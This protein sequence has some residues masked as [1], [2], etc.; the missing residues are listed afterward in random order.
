MPTGFVQPERVLRAAGFTA[1]E[2][3]Y[4]T[5]HW[6]VWE[7]MYA[8]PVRESRERLLF[9]NASCGWAHLRDARAWLDRNAG[10]RS[11]AV[12]TSNYFKLL[13]RED[14]F[15]QVTEVLGQPAPNIL[16]QS[17]FLY[18]ILTHHLGAPEAIGNDSEDPGQ[19]FFI[20]PMVRVP[21]E[22]VPQP[23]LKF[24][25]PWLTGTS[26]VAKDHNFAVLL[27]DGGAGKST[28]ARRLFDHLSRREHQVVPLLIGSRQWAGLGGQKWIELDDI[29]SSAISSCYRGAMVGPEQLET[30]VACGTIVPIFDGFDELCSLFAGSFNP[31]ETIE[32]LLE[33]C[34]E[35]NLL[36][37]SRSRFWRENIELPLASHIDQIDLEPFTLEQR[38][39]Y[40]AL[41]FAESPSKAKN[42]KLILERVR[43]A[44]HSWST[45]AP[46]L[47]EESHSIPSYHSTLDTIPFVV[48]FAAE[49]ADTDSGVVAKYGHLLSSNDPLEGLVLA[50]CERERRRQRLTLESEHQLR[51][52][53]VLATECG[54]LFSLEDI[55][56]ALDLAELANSE[57]LLRQIVRHD[58]LEQYDPRGDRVFRFKFEFIWQYLVGRIVVQWFR[59]MGNRSEAISALRTLGDVGSGLLDSVSQLLRRCLPQQEWMTLARD[60][61]IDVAESDEAAS[62]LFAVLATTARE[63]CKQIKVETTRLLLELIGNAQDAAL[64]GLRARGP[65]VGLDFKGVKVLNSRFQS[66]EF[67]NCEFDGKSV[68]GSC[69]FSGPLALSGCADFGLAKFD[70]CELSPEARSVVQKEQS[71]QSRFP[72][73]R[74]DIANAVED[75]LGRFRRGYGYQTRKMSGIDGSMN[76]RCF[77]ARELLREAQRA[78]VLEIFNSGRRRMYRIADRHS[79]ATFLD[80]GAKIGA[81]RQLIDELERQLIR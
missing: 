25:V 4:R 43:Q 71:E 73:R 37:T 10:P 16:P 58:F 48:M 46:P 78:D 41:R 36:V 15:A 80:S 11:I 33:L 79:V 81:V 74:E 21:T 40:V 12:V 6:Q 63:H 17:K 55:E 60:L 8:G 22:E 18:R 65:I 50:F 68:F 24:F 52:F 39:E 35:G 7:A 32:S 19:R 69:V 70:H 26:R 23:A 59:G 30:Y 42:A 29:W 56:I 9:L 66:V 64:S 31:T 13:S 54:S 67:I 51:V 76:Q 14:D 77:F 75:L 3:L 72:L 47:I 20:E 1:P 57:D 53:E 2:K 27:G 5:S 45:S 49:S 38:N 34:G 62:G 44:S 61:W 28:L